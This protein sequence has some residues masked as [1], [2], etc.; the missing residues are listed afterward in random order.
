METTV[1]CPKCKK[2]F[3]YKFILG[4]SVAAIRL[5]H[6]RYMRC[7]KCHKFASF[8]LTKGLI[9]KSM[10][11]LRLFQ[12]IVAGFLVAFGVLITLT[13]VYFP[14]PRSLYLYIISVALYGL[15]ALIIL[16][17]SQKKR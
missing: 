6:Y 3:K 7:Q 9:P 5:G 11:L 8:E 13:A 17:R 15:A 14:S 2:S 16:G 1:T 12:T 10:K 4:A